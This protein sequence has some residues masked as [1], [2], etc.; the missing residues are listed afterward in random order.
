MKKYRPRLE[1]LEAR[2]MPAHY[3]TGAVDG[4][5]STA[6]NWR[7]AGGGGGIVSTS[8][9]GAND[10]VYF[11]GSSPDC[12]M[13]GNVTVREL[14]LLGTFGNTLTI[15]N[16][17][18]IDVAAQVGTDVSELLA[19]T[20]AFGNSA[21]LLFGGANDDA[22]LD[23][24]GVNLNST[25][26]PK[27]SLHLYNGTL[28]NISGTP[29]RFNVGVWVGERT[30]GGN[31]QEMYAAVNVGD[32]DA[33]RNIDLVSGNNI[34]VGRYAGWV[35]ADP[36]PLTFGVPTGGGITYGVSDAMLVNKGQ[37][38]FVKAMGPGDG[39]C[40][41]GVTISNLS[42]GTVTVGTT[43]AGSY[44]LEMRPTLS[45][46]GVPNYVNVINGGTFEMAGATTLKV[47]GGIVNQSTGRF[48]VVNDMQGGAG[49]ALID[50]SRANGQNM[51]LQIANY[52]NLILNGW[53]TLT[54][55]QGQAGLFMQNNSMM[56]VYVNCYSAASKVCGYVD[57]KTGITMGTGVQLE[58]MDDYDGLNNPVFASCLIM[59][60]PAGNFSGGFSSI[61]WYGWLWTPAAG[62]GGGYDYYGLIR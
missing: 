13:G 11:D 9:P 8:A 61:N 45:L 52:G 4:T 12:W 51:D 34:V 2:L 42:T 24:R 5:W 40:P 56:T 41:L 38:A 18:S 43:G 20:V 30:V 36:N 22:L 46:S 27:G 50:S 57:V 16:S 53:L 59:G 14:H 44:T 7:S 1:A 60:C 23:M 48:R 33:L 31:L 21:K 19:G 49:K 39:A 25:G 26:S 28:C 35:F 54:N 55:Y 32:L 37:L 10:Q 62:A 58:T 29:P 3:F 6:G 47:E 15:Q 17:C